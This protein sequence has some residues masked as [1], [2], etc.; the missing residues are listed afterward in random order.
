M[1]IKTI[2]AD[3]IMPD[4]LLG[5]N[6]F[7]KVL[8]KWIKDESGWALK[9]S[10][11]TKQWSDEK[12]R[13]ITEYFCQ[14]IRRGGCVTGAFE[15]DI[16]IGF[17]LIDGTIRGELYKYV[18]LSM[19]FVVDEHK[20][21]RIG[22]RLFNAACEAARSLEAERLFISASTPMQT[23]AFYKKMGCTDACEIIPEFI[24]T[25]NDWLLEFKL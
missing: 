2:T 6:H 4:M 8:Y 18:N 13:W 12:K 19:L 3:E 25:P 17:A 22:T 15:N 5:F 16:L 10:P 14:H 24:D 23:I 11:E 9:E 21:K 1:I 20:G 7:H